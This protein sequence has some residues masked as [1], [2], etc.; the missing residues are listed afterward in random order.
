MMIHV[1]RNE[2]NGAHTMWGRVDSRVGVTIQQNSL[3]ARILA[4]E[5]LELIE[6]IE[7]DDCLDR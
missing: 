4:V 7:L 3:C 2:G 1:G 5:K 6:F